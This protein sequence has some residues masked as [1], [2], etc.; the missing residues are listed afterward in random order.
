MKALDSRVAKL[1][2]Q[3]QT[4]VSK[5]IGNHVNKVKKATYSDTNKYSM[6]QWYVAKCDDRESR[7]TVL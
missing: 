5:T 2:V 4:S 6:Y 7:S 3:V 1:E